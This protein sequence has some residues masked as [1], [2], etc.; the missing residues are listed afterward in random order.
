MCTPPPAV[1]T[2]YAYRQSVLQSMSGFVQVVLSLRDVH[3]EQPVQHVCELHSISSG[4]HSSNTEAGHSSL[5]Q[6]VQP[7]PAAT[8]ELGQSRAR[9]QGAP[10]ILCQA[11]KRLAKGTSGWAAVAC[12]LKH[13]RASTLSWVLQSAKLPPC[14][15]ALPPMHTILTQCHAAG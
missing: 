6:R 5:V 8:Q 4:H 3:H 12:I 15:S 1:C 11:N 7:I 14:F 13:T 2:Y 9:I 10:D